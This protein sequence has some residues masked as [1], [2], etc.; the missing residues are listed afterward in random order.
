MYH[1]QWLQLSREQVEAFVHVNHKYPRPKPYDPAVLNDVMKIRIAVDEAIDL[2]VRA[3]S[4][5]SSNQANSSIGAGKGIMQGAEDLGFTFGSN[6]TTTKLSKERISRMRELAV[7]KLSHAYHLDEIATS[8][9]TMQSST[10]LDD[11][12]QFALSRNPD[13]RDANYVYFF[14]EK[15]PSRRIAE[16]SPLDS[17]DRLVMQ[18]PHDASYYRTRA[19]V[20][21]FK[22]EHESAIREL[23]DGLRACQMFHSSGGDAP[24][25]AVKKN[26]HEATGV[27]AQLYFYRANSHLQ[28]S[29][30]YLAETQDVYEQTQA[31]PEDQ[32][33]IT[34]HLELRKVVKINARKAV[35]DFLSFL[36]HF[37][38]TPNQNTASKVNSRQSEQEAEHIYK[39]S[40]LFSATPP[41][42]LPPYPPI[43]LD[44]RITLPIED[45]I[46]DDTNE[47]VTFH[48]L[49]PEGLCSL[50]ISHIV[51][52]TP[53]TELRRHTYNA[54]RLI[55]LLT[56]TPLFLM[57]R[58]SSAATWQDV[59]QCTNNWLDLSHSWL[60]LCGRE[61]A[62][63]GAGWLPT[64]ESR[65]SEQMRQDV[66]LNKAVL[67]AAADETTG[68]QSLDAAI[69]SRLQIAQIAES[70]RSAGRGLILAKGSEL[71]L[72]RRWSPQLNFDEMTADMSKPLVKWVLEAPTLLEGE[73]TKAG[74]KKKRRKKPAT[75]LEESVASL[76][77][78]GADEVDE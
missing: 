36:S 74:A 35:R 40:D 27:E 57:G 54:A 29:F 17:L 8:V 23:S 59:L 34:K 6:G 30:K 3:A 21:L 69:R 7:Q 52:Q 11:I 39:V 46:Q 9:A 14:H 44:E 41:S 32:Q 56:G 51:A 48:P 43:D 28:I 16:F 31:D 1:G 22:A 66:K 76:I 55:R 25:D 49:L 12:A 13:N 58:S 33:L 53:T 61:I 73:K 63:F 5:V 10:T 45:P 15:I 70:E 42:T 65:M 68:G 78:A 62:L 26:E 67:A 18:S 75:G 37:E 71:G 60:G 20:K 72:K 2:A 64:S 77:V 38:Y 19:V 47:R 24:F 4:G 50:L